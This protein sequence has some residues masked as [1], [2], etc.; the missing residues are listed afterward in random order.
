MF[1]RQ[2]YYNQLV[3]IGYFADDGPL[4]LHQMFNY[5]LASTNKCNYNQYYEITTQNDYN[6]EYIFI[7]KNGTH[8]VINKFKIEPENQLK[9][10]GDL[11]FSIGVGSTEKSIFNNNNNYKMVVIRDPISRAI[12]S[13]QEMLK[14]REDCPWSTPI[15]RKLM[16]YKTRD[17]VEKSFAYFLHEIYKYGF[18]DQH[19]FSQ[20]E[21]IN[22]ELLYYK[23]F[24][25]NIFILFEN[26]K[27]ELEEVAKIHKIDS[28][29]DEEAKSQFINKGSSEVKE[30][31][32]KLITENDKYLKVIKHL[33]SEDF[34]LYEKVKNED[35]FYR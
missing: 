18:Y 22:N 4:P 12:S 27:D 10:V 30:R 25:N 21:C 14:L 11:S 6:I 29:S 28:I 31:I 35:R 32:M 19:I 1:D 15:T 2:K 34:K 8:Y 13:Y 5:N 9:G 33:Y 24:K 23:S 26:M 20:Y 7:P 3:A 16:F 17:N